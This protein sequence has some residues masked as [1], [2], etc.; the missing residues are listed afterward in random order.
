MKAFKYFEAELIQ[1]IEEEK[2]KDATTDFPDKEKFQ[3]LMEWLERGGAEIKK[4]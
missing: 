1:D 2:E 4:V 3:K